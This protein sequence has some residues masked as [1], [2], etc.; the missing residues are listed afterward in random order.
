MDKLAFL[1]VRYDKE[2]NAKTRGKEMELSTPDSL[3]KAFVIPTDE[4]GKIAEETFKL[5]S[6]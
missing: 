1:G 4:E 5:C 6:K 3:I 2:L